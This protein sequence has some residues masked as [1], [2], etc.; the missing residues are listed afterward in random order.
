MADHKRKHAN[1]LSSAQKENH[2]PKKV[3]R[4]VSI[5][6]LYDQQT[7]KRLNSDGRPS[8]ALKHTAV[9]KQTY[10]KNFFAQ[11]G[12]SKKAEQ[13]PIYRDFKGRCTTL[14]WRSQLTN[15]YRSDPSLQRRRVNDKFSST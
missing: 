7:R 2:P 15:H 5:A 12:K 6:G 10:P 3:K 14:L 1:E 4:K 11:F 8:F 13:H 9:S